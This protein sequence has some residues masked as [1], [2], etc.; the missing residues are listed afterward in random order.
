MIIEASAL[1]GARLGGQHT[2]EGDCLC[3][4]VDVDRWI[5]KERGRE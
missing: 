5:D 2:N 3:V 1:D 4:C